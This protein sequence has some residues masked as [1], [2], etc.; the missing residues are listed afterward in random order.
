MQRDEQPQLR[1]RAAKAADVATT[2]EQRPRG[3]SA[4]ASARQSRTAI[5]VFAL[6]GKDVRT[7][8]TLLEHKIG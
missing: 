1:Q 4:A 2:S 8:F 5:I 6:Y 7:P 3:T